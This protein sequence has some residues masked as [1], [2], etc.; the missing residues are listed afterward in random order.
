MGV[1]LCTPLRFGFCMQYTFVLVIK[2][3]LLDLRGQE[4]V[5]SREE[6]QVVREEGGQP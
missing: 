5:R 1:G 4:Q 2:D 6:L 3:I